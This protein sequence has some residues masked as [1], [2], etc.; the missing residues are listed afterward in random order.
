M[1]ALRVPEWETEFDRVKVRMKLDQS[2]SSP[3]AAHFDQLE[4]SAG[5]V[6]VNLA[7][8][9]ATFDAK[10]G[11]SLNVAK[12]QVNTGSGRQKLSRAVRDALANLKLV[13]GAEFSLTASGPADLR[14]FRRVNCELRLTPSGLS[15]QVPGMGDPF[16]HFTDARFVLKDGVLSGQTLRALC[17]DDVLFV[18]SVDWDLKDLP[19]RYTFRAVTGCVTP[20]KR[21][22]GYPS[23]VA[24]S[25]N[26]YQPMGPFFVEGKIGVDTGGPD[27]KVDYDAQV[28]TP[29]GRF[30]FASGRIP[31]YNV[32]AD[33]HVT[34][35]ELD[36][37][38][39]EADALTGRISAN[40]KVNLTAAPKYAFDM[41]ARGLDLK[42]FG[43]QYV[44]PGRPA[45]PLSGRGTLNATLS[46]VVPE[47]GPAVNRLLAHGTFD[48]RE[49]ELYRIPFI[50]SINKAANNDDSNVV[51]DAAAAFHIAGGKVYFD[52]AILSSP[53]LG[54][55]GVGTIDFDG[56]IDFNKVI[57]TVG[58]DW[59]RNSRD[60]GAVGKVLGTVQGAVNQATRLAFYE[61]K[62][63]GKLDSPKVV[64][65][66]LPFLADTFKYF[67]LLKKEGPGP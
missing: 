30:S 6:S 37:K 49:G 60:D 34:P 45:L 21:H 13:G 63:S 3:P 43:R 19:R 32:R 41:R 25:M 23:A 33:C 35:S 44:E 31:V 42:Q 62:V 51:S 57:A 59:E 2:P 53:T 11:W 24:M 65:V 48:I 4:A 9:S 67:D 66:P 36:L 18:R 28:H 17:A 55:E 58:G 8:S 39:F 61:M 52:R 47:K 12:G 29:R 16:D 5:D 22:G 38:S 27:V 7:D 15:L 14:D 26:L 40:G 10:A 56:N 1:T 20:G 54:C 50:H 64:P 46:G